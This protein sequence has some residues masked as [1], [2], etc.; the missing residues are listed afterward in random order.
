MTTLHY[1]HRMK[2]PYDTVTVLMM[3]TCV[4]IDAIRYWIRVY[5]LELHTD[6]SITRH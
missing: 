5:E 4:L 1:D 3:I 6:L 2:L